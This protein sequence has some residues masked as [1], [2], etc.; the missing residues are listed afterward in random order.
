[1]T[2]WFCDA[3]QDLPP[4]LDG[5]FMPIGQPVGKRCAY[6]LDAE[7][8]L[9]PLGAI[10]ELYIGGGGLARGYLDRPGLTAERFV[11]D[12]FDP[13]GERLYRT[14]DLVRWRS[15]GQLE[16][17]GRADQ[18]IKLRGFR[19]ELGEIEAQ[20]LTLDHVCEAA[21][22][23]QDGAHGL[24]LIAYVG[25]PDAGHRNASA[26]KTALSA[27]LPDYMVPGLIVFLDTL[28]LTP[29]GKIDRQALPALGILEVPD[30]DA[31]VNDLEAKIAGI[32]AALLQIPQVGL[33]HNFFDLGGHSLLLIKVKQRLEAE[34]HVPVA[35]VDLFKYT[36]V[37][38]LAKFL[39][40]GEIQPVSSL[41][42]H[43]QRAQR[44]RGA[45]LAR[46]QKVEKMN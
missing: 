40:Q 17:W 3:G 44:Q 45:F 37:A 24:R 22:I 33:H 38:S 30:Y 10:G 18:Q 6:V 46:K 27:V 23:A 20:L 36:T 21:V 13:Q 43:L 39:G 15:D 1:P 5:E 32:W 25:M 34:L 29:N 4:P 7:L 28:P 31:P 11:A 26:L 41:P 2:A 35:I 12:P 14:G 42:R 9:A 16:Y 8:N 19:V